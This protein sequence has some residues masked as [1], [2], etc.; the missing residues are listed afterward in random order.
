MNSRDV[1]WVVRKA[2]AII[3]ACGFVA[4]LGVFVASFFGLTLD[5]M[6][7]KQLLVLHGGIFVLAVALSTI[8]KPKLAW[9]RWSR[10]GEL[11]RGMPRPV[12]WG[13][14]IF[15]G[16][17]IVISLTF[18]ILGHAS[19]PEIRDGSYVLNDH[20]RIVR[21]ISE[22]EYLRLKGWEL[23]LFASGWMCVYYSLITYFWFPRKEETPWS[24][25]P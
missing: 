4:G 12:A 11:D 9:P 21:W 1:E 19:A 25:D 6:G 18:L 13:L 22:G 14:T 16:F 15:F 23:R 20:G 3:A 10:R 5:R 17:F 7:M 2:G 8:E 24:V